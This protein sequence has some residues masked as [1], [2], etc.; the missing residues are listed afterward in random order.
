MLMR[1]VGGL[2]LTSLARTPGARLGRDPSYAGVE[3]RLGLFQVRRVKAFREAMIGF[4]QQIA[5]V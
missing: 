3:R 4:A 5:G 1:K 2:V